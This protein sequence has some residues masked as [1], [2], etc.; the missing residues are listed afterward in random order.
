MELLRC[1]VERKTYENEE[2]GYSILQT[3]VKNYNNLVTV[4]GNMSGVYVGSV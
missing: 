4:V 2:N 1:V 3:H